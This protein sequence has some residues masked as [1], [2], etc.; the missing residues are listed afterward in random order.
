M[1]FKD[2]LPVINKRTK[3][4]VLLCFGAKIFLVN[5]VKWLLGCCKWLLGCSYEVVMSLLI[6]YLIGRVK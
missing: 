4:V 5:V 3:P 1:I 6:G 2:Y